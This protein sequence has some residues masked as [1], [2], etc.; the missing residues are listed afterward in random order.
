MKQ[1]SLKKIRLIVA[2]LFLLF[3]LF[4]FI[5]FRLIIPTSWYKSI[6]FLQF[7]PSLLNFISILSIAA[8]GFIIILIVSL[9]FGRVYCSAICPLGILM[10]VISRIAKIFRR[11]KIYRYGKAH[12]IF[13]YGFLIMS[14]G[15][16]LFGSMLIINLLDPF[17]NFGR[18]S[19]NLVRPALLFVNNSLTGVFESI[20]I[21]TLYRVKF[22]TANMVAILFPAGFLMLIIYFAS[23][24][25]RLYCNS[26]CP[27]GTLLGL[28]SRVSI[29]KVMINRTSCTLCGDC[30]RVC[31]ASCINIKEAKVDMSRCVACYNCFTSC[32]EGG[33]KYMLSTKPAESLVPLES[34][35]KK[36]KTLIS[37]LTLLAASLPVRSLTQGMGYGKHLGTDGSIPINKYYPVSPPGSKSIE[38]FTNFCTACHLCISACPTQVLQPSLF[39]YGFEGILQ[40]H[41]DFHHSFCNYDC[42]ICSQVCPSG[43]ILPLSVDQKHRTQIGVVQLV[44]D[45][46]VVVARHKDC[47]SCAEH[48]PTQAVHMVPWEK[49]LKIPALNWDICIG[50]GACEFA[51]PTKPNKA[52]FVDGNPMHLSVSKAKSKQTDQVFSPEDDFPF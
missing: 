25:G 22:E 12:N 44:L 49:N 7:I 11:R 6:L 27:V 18:I 41:L 20:G 38:H 32:P 13:R 8:S 30:S 28:L 39:Q 24:H 43:A 35:R 29:F 15:F 42:V 2:L 10:D 48:C 37:L 34:D 26:V 51:C 21:Y 23:F 46:C 3:T 17:S 36:R 19:T 33:I 4:I 16:I 52:I 14:L 31:K 40:P 5:D 1:A 50:C 47:G 45:N 9:L